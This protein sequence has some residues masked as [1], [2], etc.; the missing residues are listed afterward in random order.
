MNADLVATLR[1]LVLSLPSV[2]AVAGSRI[3]MSAD[4]PAGYDPRAVAAT[5]ALTG[6]AILFSD[7]GGRVGPT[8]VIV[9][10]TYQVRCYAADA[11]TAGDL[12]ARLFTALHDRARGRI[13]AVRCTTTGQ[14]VSD[15]P[16]TGWHLFLSSWQVTAVFA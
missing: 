7:R 10:T 16:Q 4:L 13:R 5:V 6:P 12:D 15:Y 11:V 1:T 14:H 3:F 8:S 9:E 2:V